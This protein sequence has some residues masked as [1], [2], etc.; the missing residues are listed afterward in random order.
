M[1]RLKLCLAIFVLLTATLACG[2][3]GGQTPEPPTEALVTEPAE[4][5]TREA[6]YTCP[7]GFMAGTALTV[8]FCYP[9]G[10]ATGYDQQLIPE[11]QPDP[12][13]AYWDFNPDTIEIE[14]TGYPISNEYHQ[15]QVHIY[16]VADYVALEPDI[17]VTVNELQSLLT[18]QDPNPSAIPFLPIYNAAQMMQAK[19]TYLDFRSGAG[20]RFITQYGQAAMPINNVSAIYAFMGLTADGQY[21]VSATFPVTHPDFAADNMTEPVEGWATFSENYETYV[22]DMETSLAA[23]ADDA[24]TPDLA[25]LDTMMESFMVPATAIP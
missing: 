8:E 18:S 15:P 20:V 22:N 23:Q 1:T 4:E 3:P 6:A 17:Q 2:L 25:M 9:N 19:V 11:L 13:T 7:A 21:I 12:N 10:Y 24:F 16:P 14:L 5:V